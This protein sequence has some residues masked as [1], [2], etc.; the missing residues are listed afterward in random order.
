MTFT[1]KILASAM[2]LAAVVPPATANPITMATWGGAYGKSQQETFVKDF[3]QKTGVK[4]LIEDY[5]G[6][7][8]QIRSQVKS[9]NVTWDV[10]DLEMQDAVRACDEGLLERMDASI[11]T[12]S[13]DGTS[14]ADDFVKGAIT[15]CAVGSLTW[16]NI[17]AY[18]DTRFNGAKP[19]SVKDF[20]DLKKFPGKRG[21]KKAARANLELALLAD[22]VPTADVYKVLGAPGGIGR[23]LK[24]RHHQEQYCLVGG[25][26]TTATIAVEWRGRDDHLV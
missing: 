13:R 17:I 5:S 24:A 18:N 26:C 19:S 4:V 2:V 11:L 15:K 12:A 25:R 21:M 1:L 10:V 8:A 14:V 7:L 3:M 9:G 16:A 20:F 6:G 22:G 23:A